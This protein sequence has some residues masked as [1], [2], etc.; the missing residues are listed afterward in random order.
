MIDQ[1]HVNMPDPQINLAAAQA[2]VQGNGG[3]GFAAPTAG[4]GATAGQGNVQ[5]MGVARAANF[6]GPGV[7]L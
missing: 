7:K 3:A 1:S 6:P 4:A 2:A 5:G